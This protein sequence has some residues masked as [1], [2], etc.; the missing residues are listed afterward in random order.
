MFDNNQENNQ[1][2]LAD[3]A[4]INQG[5]LAEK[6]NINVNS[7]DNGGDGAS[8]GAAGGNTESSAYDYSYNKAGNASADSR[9]AGSANTNNAENTGDT[10]RK[11]NRSS[12]LI[13]LVI[14]VVYILFTLIAPAGT[15]NNNSNASTTKRE[16]LDVE[17][18]LTDY[19]SGTSIWS[20]APSL[21]NQMQYF[22]DKTG[23]Q[24]YLLDLTGE[25]A[26][27]EDELAQ[28]ADDFYKE[29]F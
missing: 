16:K 18:Q 15:C 2:S 17:V 10:I 19:F 27:T 14:I 5:S 8:Q 23:C 25:A 13:L 7:I 11:N 4:N 9:N 12:L 21:E 22:Y 28:K 1:S 26:L 20:Q 24:P 6:A 3:K 29:T